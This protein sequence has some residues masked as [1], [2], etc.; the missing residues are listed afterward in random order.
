M[1]SAAAKDTTKISAPAQKS[2]TDTAEMTTK[3]SQETAQDSKEK[4]KSS[5]SKQKYA[6]S[7][8]R[9]FENFSE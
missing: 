1:Q 9:Q 3:R 7:D 6:Y 8:Y 4:K 5:I 2:D